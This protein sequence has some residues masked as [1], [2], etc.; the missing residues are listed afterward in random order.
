CHQHQR[1]HYP[2]R[3][4]TGQMPPDPPIH[5]NAP[6]SRTTSTPGEQCQPDA[7]T[8]PNT[9]PPGTTNSST[10]RRPEPSATTAGTDLPQ[11]L[12]VSTAV[13]PL[14]ELLHQHRLDAHA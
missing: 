8:T 11:H 10:P 4:R 1:R 14:L 9:T 5:H 13:R 12:F 6:I 2:Q 3:E 7:T